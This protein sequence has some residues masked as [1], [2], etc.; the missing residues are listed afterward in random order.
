MS[1]QGSS[2]RFDVV[3]IGG[4]QAGLAMGYHLAKRDVNFVIL[5]S[6]SR[7]GAAW[8]VRW[9]SLR[10]FTPAR[11]DGLPGMAFPGRP[12][13]LPTK[14]EFADYLEAY[15]SRFKLPIRLGTSVD[16][17]GL[18]GERFVVAS[19]QRR[20]EADQVVVATGGHPDPIRPGFASELDADILQLHSSEYRNPSQLRDGEVLVVGAGNSGAEVAIG[21]APNH[22]TWLAGRCTGTVPPLLYSRSFWWMITRLG[23][24]NTAAGRKMRARALTGGTPLV[25]LRPKDFGAAGV[26][27]VGRVAGIQDGKPRLEDGQLLHVKNVVWCTGFGHDYSWIHGPTL[28]DGHIPPHERGVVRSIPGLYFV[29]LPFQFGLSSALIDGVGRDAEY[30]AERIVASTG[31]RGELRERE[32]RRDLPD[33][34]PARGVADYRR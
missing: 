8:R 27:R 33:S 26:I 16:S 17:A 12:G 9:D 28:G 23:T 30:I 34:M 3:V 25:R 4:G 29:G 19:G 1:A 15:A 10:L 24:V 31:A 11:L 20:F 32:G 18:V 7:V 2:E 13:A 22:R 5:D 21:A 14:D 6:H